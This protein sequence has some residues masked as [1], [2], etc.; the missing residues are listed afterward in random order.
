MFQ[1]SGHTGTPYDITHA[2]KRCS[3]ESRSEGDKNQKKSDNH[4]ARGV[5]KA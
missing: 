1:L 2:D 5:N 4:R 3:M